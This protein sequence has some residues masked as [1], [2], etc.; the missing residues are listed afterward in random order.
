VITVSIKRK[1][2]LN[3]GLKYVYNGNMPGHAG[4]NTFCFRC[5]QMVIERWGFQVGKMRMENGRCSECSA[6]IDG[7][8]S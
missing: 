5:G 1:I 7:V 2:G 6:E 8:W 4:E 3:V